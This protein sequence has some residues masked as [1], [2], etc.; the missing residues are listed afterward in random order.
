VPSESSAITV[1]RLACPRCGDVE[2]LPAS[3]AVQIH[4]GG[5][6]Y[7]FR[8]PLCLRVEVTQADEHALALLACAEVRVTKPISGEELR[9]FCTELSRV[10]HALAAESCKWESTDESEY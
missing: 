2:V 4:S 8:C 1:V 9:D 5:A 7:A 3:M 6:H 10:E